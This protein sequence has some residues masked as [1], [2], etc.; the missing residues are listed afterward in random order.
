MKDLKNDY[1]Q[2]ISGLEKCKRSLAANA[3]PAQV[4]HQR[5]TLLASHLLYN[6][7][8]IKLRADL[9]TIHRLV[10]N[11]IIKDEP[12]HDAVLAVHNWSVT[13][14]ALVATEHACATWLLVATEMKRPADGRASFSVLSHIALFHA[15][16]VVWAYACTRREPTANRLDLDQLATTNSEVEDLRMYRANNAVLMVHFADLLKEISPVWARASSYYM[17]VSAIGENPLPLLS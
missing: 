10:L 12:C 7:S 17:T 5:N 3:T 8:I 16:V 2:I 13:A 1:D 4:I 6:L 9:R 14:E 15:A 11:N